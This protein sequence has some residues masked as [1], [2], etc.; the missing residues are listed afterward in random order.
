MFCIAGIY[1]HILPGVLLSLQ[2]DET[3]FDLV[4]AKTAVTGI[5]RYCTLIAE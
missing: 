4:S 2:I 5:C 3:G 1:Y